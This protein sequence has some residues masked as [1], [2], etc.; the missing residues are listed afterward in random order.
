MELACKH[1]VCLIPYGG[2]DRIILNH[3]NEFHPEKPF[4]GYYALTFK[5]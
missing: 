4:S 3:A 1:S 2:E 5:S